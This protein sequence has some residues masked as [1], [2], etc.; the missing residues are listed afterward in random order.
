MKCG[1]YAETGD[2]KIQGI[3]I[4]CTR[5]AGHSGLCSAE[6][7][8]WEHSGSLRREVYIKVQWKAKYKAKVQP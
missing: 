5:T 3:G 8:G 7:P 4:F 1:N 6:L 2:T